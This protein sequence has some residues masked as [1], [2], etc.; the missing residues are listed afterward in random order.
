MSFKIA[1]SV[2]LAVF[3]VAIASAKTPDEI[4]S[5]KCAKEYKLEKAVIDKFNKTR[6]IETKDKNIKCYLKCL[7]TESKLMNAK[8]EFTL[9]KFEDNKKFAELSH[10]CKTVNNADLCE[11]AFL[12]HKCI[13]E[14]KEAKEGK[15]KKE[16][17]AAG[18]KG[19]KQ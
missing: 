2:L 12:F 19:H 18:H 10:A 8:G 9:P 6:P 7:L 16:G 13:L 17:K 14:K 4:I 11:K 1:L 3:F 15:E 5:E